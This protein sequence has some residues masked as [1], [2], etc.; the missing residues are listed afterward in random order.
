MGL[1]LKD[2]MAKPW[3]NGKEVPRLGVAEIQKMSPSTTRRCEDRSL[4]LLM[5]GGAME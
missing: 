2:F 3:N 1:Y 5:L 4:L